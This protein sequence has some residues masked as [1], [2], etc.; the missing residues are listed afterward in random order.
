MRAVLQFGKLCPLH[1]VLACVTFKKHMLYPQTRHVVHARPAPTTRFNVIA[2][3]ASEARFQ[4]VVTKLKKKKKKMCLDPKSPCEWLHFRSQLSRCNTHIHTR[5]FICI[6]CTP[7]CP[8]RYTYVAYSYIQ[9]YTRAAWTC[10]IK[11]TYE[12]RCPHS[13]PS[14]PSTTWRLGGVLRSM[15]LYVCLSL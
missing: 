12:S 10:V 8:Y 13:Y 14:I 9:T 11:T 1:G 2:T 15:C 4:T 5:E 7:S 3:H 6:L